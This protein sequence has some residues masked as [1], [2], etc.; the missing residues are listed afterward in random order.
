LCFQSGDVA[1][2]GIDLSA[3]A[4]MRKVTAPVG[5]TLP[6]MHGL[7]SDGFAQT[8]QP[9]LGRRCYRSHNV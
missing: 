3:V 2:Y 4:R 8:E 6:G 7:I 5:A 9:A 1:A